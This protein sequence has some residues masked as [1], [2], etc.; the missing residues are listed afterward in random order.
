MILHEQNNFPGLS[1]RLLSRISTIV[2]LAFPDAGRRLGGKKKRM[3]GNPIRTGMQVQDKHIARKAL[4]LNPDR[5]TLLVFGGSQG[6]R[7]INRAV[8]Q[9]LPVLIGEQ[10]QVLWQTGKSDLDMAAAVANDYQ[11][12]VV[13][14]DFIED[15]AQAYS[16]ADLALTRAGAMTVTELTQMGVPALMIPLPT[17]AENHQEYNAIAM[18]KSHAARMIREVD[19]DGNRLS[20][21]IIALF[22]DEDRLQSMQVSTRKLAVSDSAERI[23]CELMG[24]G[25]LTN[26]F[27][28]P[29]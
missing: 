25:M 27:R 13:V 18:G 8:A 4:N 14:T 19:L 29:A 15:M 21:E 24:S 6:A 3:V 12:C 16:A 5:K 1:V 28:R 23:V 17:S 7:G 20:D 11:G 9:A 10:I 2:F 26:P 22:N